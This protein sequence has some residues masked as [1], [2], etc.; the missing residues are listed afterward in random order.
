M[1]E[2]P[3]IPFKGESPVVR[4]CIESTRAEYAGRLEEA[5]AL[6]ARAMDLAADDYE[7]CIAAHYAARY[8]EDAETALRLNRIALARAQK[9]GDQR[10]A[11]FFPSL[12]VNLGQAYERV[13]D[14]EQ[15]RRYYALA[16]ELGLDHDPRGL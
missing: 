7:I 9:S 12:Y 6:V 5:R 1:E 3:T 2:T 14:Q 16:A 4:L 15:A 13:G 10:A 11:A 8:E